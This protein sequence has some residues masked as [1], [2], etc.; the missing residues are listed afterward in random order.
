MIDSPNQGVQDREHLKGL[1]TAVAAS[2][3]K[4]AQ[5]ILAHEEVPE[6]FALNLTL[7]LTK[8]QRVLT[9]EGFQGVSASLFDYVELARASLARVGSVAEDPENEGEIAE[10]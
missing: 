8:G 6:S 4:Q 2:A 1:L 9:N 5:V 10:D 7:H 3:P